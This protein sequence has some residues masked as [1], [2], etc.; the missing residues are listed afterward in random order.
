MWCWWFRLSWSLW[1]SFWQ[2]ERGQLI[3]GHWDNKKIT[4]ITDFVDDMVFDKRAKKW[5]FFC[6]FVKFC[7][8]VE[9]FY[10]KIFLFSQC[11]VNP[12]P[13]FS[14]PLVISLNNVPK[15]PLIISKNFNI[16]VFTEKFSKRWVWQLGV[17]MIHFHS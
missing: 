13:R 11:E 4:V 5:S 12:I 6:S 7:L 10:H 1:L 14:F 8:F 9:F 2:Q 15:P 17:K 16:Y 3:L